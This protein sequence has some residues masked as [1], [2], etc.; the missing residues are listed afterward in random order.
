MI[1][2]NVFL[3]IET[4]HHFQRDRL[5]SKNSIFRLKLFRVGAQKKSVSDA[6]KAL[7]PNVVPASHKMTSVSPPPPSLSL[8]LSLSSIIF[9]SVCLSLCRSPF[10]FVF[11]S[12][13]RSLFLFVFLS[14]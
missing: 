3:S 5:D 13:C 9:F 6:I 2:K 11:I 4:L 12:L 14:L 7:K 1:T 10:L 8:S